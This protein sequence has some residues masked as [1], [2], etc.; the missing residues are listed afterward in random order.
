MN[1]EII[2]DRIEE[3]GNVRVVGFFSAE[4]VLL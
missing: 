2:R 4:D 3:I 1:K